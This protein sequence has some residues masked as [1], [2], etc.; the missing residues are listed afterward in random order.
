MVALREGSGSLTA[1]QFAAIFGTT[2]PLF[3]G[4]AP[5]VERLCY[6]GPNPPAQV[7]VTVTTLDS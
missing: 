1:S 2:T 5:L 6:S 7:S 4:G 3:S